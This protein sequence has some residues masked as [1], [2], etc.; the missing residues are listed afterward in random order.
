MC[1]AYIYSQ[2][3]AT[4]L[5]RK[6]RDDIFKKQAQSGKRRKLRSS[7]SGLAGVPMTE[8]NG[9]PHNFMSGSESEGNK[10]GSNAENEDPV[11]GASRNRISSLNR[12]SLP[13]FLPA[14]YLD[15]TDPQEAKRQ[16]QRPKQVS[17]MRLQEPREKRTTDRRIGGTIYR[18]MKT[19]NSNLAPKAN[20][21]AR[22]MKEKWLQG[23]LGKLEK[24]SRKQFPSGFIK[25]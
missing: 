20:L 18:V 17:K 8:A 4:R 2:L 24:S 12:H 22:S 25:K 14:E 10:E 13:E 3:S 16:E 5:K 21:Q 6:A 11:E 1:S 19:Q 15:D 9:E 23:R 7:I